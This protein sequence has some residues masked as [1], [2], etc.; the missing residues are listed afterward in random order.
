MRGTIVSNDGV[1]WSW[2]AEVEIAEAGEAEHQSRRVAAGGEA[3]GPGAAGLV[4]A[5]DALPSNRLRDRGVA[6]IAEDFAGFDE[7]LGVPGGAV[8]EREHRRR[9]QRRQR[10]VGAA[11][12]GAGVLEN[13]LALRESVRVQAAQADAGRAVTPA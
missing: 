1:A 10:R 8:A 12:R 4:V 3:G 11:Q 2:R 7:Q 13:V 9:L 6:G 5:L